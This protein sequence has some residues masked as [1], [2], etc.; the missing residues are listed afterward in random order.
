MISTLTILTSFFFYHALVVADITKKISSE[1]GV[2][3]EGGGV[4]LRGTFI[5]DPEQVVKHISINDLGVG[6]S[7]DEVLRLVE[8]FQFVAEHGE[9]CPAGWTKGEK[10]MIPDSVKA[11]DYFKAVN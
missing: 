9:V 4:A 10:T 11:K 8:G 1:Y 6:R 2:L 3:L 5:I 7:V